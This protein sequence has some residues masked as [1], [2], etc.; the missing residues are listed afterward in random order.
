MY[1][2]SDI[3]R[4]MDLVDRL[5]H[6]NEVLQSVNVKLSQ[7]IDDLESKLKRYDDATVEELLFRNSQLENLMEEKEA[8]CL[9]WKQKYNCLL[10]SRTT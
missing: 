8:E 6:Q 10:T 3:N 2:G 1:A 9:D 5:G 4:Q 7:K